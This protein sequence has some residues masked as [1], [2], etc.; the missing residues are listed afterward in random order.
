[1][2]T[3][4]ALFCCLV[5]LWTPSAFAQQTD[6]T[7]LY[8][9]H[10]MGYQGW[11]TC[12]SDGQRAM[13]WR[14]WFRDARPGSRNLVFDMWPDTTALS[15]N[16]R[17][18]TGLKLPNGQ[19]AYLF[20]AENPTTVERHFEWM[21]KNNID[22]IAVQRFVA[23][24]DDPSIR[25]H[26][27]KVLA[28]V[29]AAAARNDRAFFLMYDLSANPQTKPQDLLATLRAD[30]RQLVK[31]KEI[32]AS[33]NYL[34]HRG[35]PV[36]A[37]WG[38]GVGNSIVGPDQSLALIG[39]LKQGAETGVAVTILGGV[40]SYWRT[41]GNDARKDPKWLEVYGALDVLSP[42]TVG[43]YRDDVTADRFLDTVARPDIAW[44][45]SRGIDYMPVVF[46]GFSAS[47]A[48]Q[49]PA[50]VNRI[51]RRCG[52]FYWHQVTNVTGAGAKML[53]TAMFDEV[54]EGTAM[55]EIVPDSADV[56][57]AVRSVPLNADGCN[58]PRDWYLQL[59]GAATK[60]LNG[61]IPLDKDFM[62]FM[63]H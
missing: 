11:F 50:A 47:N 35:K 24:L 18:D 40:P 49:D 51:P 55:F 32:L 48:K 53:Y 27:D 37:I 28:N 39:E 36:L 22:G 26:D 38:F 3:R 41:L 7:T 45:K 12:P 14:H 23:G 61:K 8:R 6:Y 4:N 60:A 57:S 9:K 10:I 1:M 31:N 15:L 13:P 34:R 2:Q 54:N 58:L 43:R 30:W 17:C 25:N 42:W 59:A 16:E 44:T 56:P 33:P 52:Q 20:S 21:R 63:A 5:T 62:R 19:P 29:A 46:P